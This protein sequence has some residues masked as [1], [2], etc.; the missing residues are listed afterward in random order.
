LVLKNLHSVGLLVSYV[1][2]GKT[3]L[4]KKWN[5]PFCNL[6]VRGILHP[7]KFLPL[8]FVRLSPHHQYFKTSLTLEGEGSKIPDI[9]MLKQLG[10]NKPSSLFWPG[11][12]AAK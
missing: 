8:T 3:Q 10:N 1:T 9:S 7:C 6:K 5:A 2:H 11:Y 12:N 4:Y